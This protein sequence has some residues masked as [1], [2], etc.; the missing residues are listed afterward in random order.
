MLISAISKHL[1]RELGAP[2]IST[3]TEIKTYLKS[4]AKNPQLTVTDF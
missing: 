4:G 2:T 1:K 3:E